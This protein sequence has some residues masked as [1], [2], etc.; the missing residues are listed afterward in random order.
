[1]SPK[2]LQAILIEVELTRETSSYSEGI[3]TSIIEPSPYRTTPA[4]PHANTCGGCP[5][6]HITYPAQLEA[7][8]SNVVNQLSRIGGFS[9]DEAENLVGPCVPSKRELGY[10]NKL[11]FSTG[12]DQQGKFALGLHEHGWNFYSNPQAMSTRC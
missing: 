5:W 9:R 3:A 10:R 8:R 12:Y 11:E 6:M 7:K 1:M 4:C 2:Q